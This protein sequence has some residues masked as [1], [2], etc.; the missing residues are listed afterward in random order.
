MY[1]YGEPLHRLYCYGK[2]IAI[3]IGIKLAIRDDQSTLSE[4][5]YFYEIS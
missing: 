4:G 1:L 2:E 3:Y 5:F